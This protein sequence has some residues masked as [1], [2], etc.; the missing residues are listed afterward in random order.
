MTV[1]LRTLRIVSDFSAA[2]Y[3]A[4][5]NEKVAA[6]RAGVA[7]SKAV[8]AA[9]DEQKIKVSSAVPLIEKLSRTYVDGYGTAAK[10][11][12]EVLK[13]ARS[14]DT[15]ASSVEHLELV[16]TGLQ[17]KFGLVADATELT[18]RGY[19]EL[20]AAIENVN[21]RLNQ[22]GGAEQ[23][24]ALASRVEQLRQ[25]FDPTYVAAQRLSSELS[26]L[27]E[28]ER[29]G[30]QITGGYERALE[31]IIVKHDATA[32]AAKR[33]R[34]EYTRLAQEGREA[35]AADRAQAGFN[36]F[37]GI[38]R[39]P[40]SR[41]SDSAAFF[42]E[43]LARQEELARLRAQQEGAGFAADLNQRFAFNGYGTSAQ[44]SA[45]VFAAE[46]ARQD[47]L[48]RLREQQR[49]AAFSSD[50]NDRL[51]VN[52]FGT[53]ARASASA[54]EE[55]ARAAEY[56]ER[57]A[58]SLRAQIDPLGAAQNRLNAELAEYEELARRSAISAEELTQGQAVARQR[59]DATQEN[60]NR[61]PTLGQRVG[62]LQPHQV[63]NLLYQGYDVAQSLALGMPAIQVFL[64]QG[65]QIAQIFQ[66]G[67]GATKALV[68][69]LTPLNIAL[70]GV[71]AAVL[72]GA[73]AWNDY[74]VSTKAVETA[75]AG[76]GRTMAG[77]AA[78]MEA[79]A[80]AGAEAAN[81]SVSAARSLEAQFL[82]T[83]KIGYE[84][85]EQ[86]IGVSKDFAA[87]LGIDSAAAGTKLSEMFA[88][89]AQ[90]AE[91]LYRQY[92]LISPATAEYV[93]RLVAQ[94]RAAEAQSVLL[95]ALPI[96]LAD[97]TEA[98]TAFGRAWEGVATAA[99]NSWDYIGKAIDRATTGPSLE[100]R[101]NDAA[102]RFERFSS[103][104]TP[105]LGF[106]GARR[107]RAEEARVELEDL[108]EQ[109]RRQQQLQA[110][111]DAER[112]QE[113]LIARGRD[114]ALGSGATS[115]VRQQRQLAD[116]IT[117]LQRSLS[118]D[119]LSPDARNDM[120][121]ALE[122]KT[123]VLD[124]LINRQQR[125]AELDRLDIQI[126]Q[127][128]NPLLRADLE[129]RRTRLQMADQEVESSRIAV[130]ADRAR[131]RV[132]EETIAVAA[133]QAR[134]LQ[135]EIEVRT[136]LDNLVAAGTLTRADANR[137][138]QEEATLRPLVAAAAAAEG[139]EQERLLQVVEQLRGAYAGLAEEQKRAAAI[140]YLTSIN[141]R[142]EQLRL[143]QSLIGANQNVRGRAT[144][145]LE[146]EQRIRRMGLDT[147]S[148]MADRIREETD[149]LARQ[150][151][152][153]N[154]QA[155]AWKEVQSS[156]ES[157][158]DSAVERLSEGDWKGA[159]QDVTKE[160]QSSLLK[161][162]VTNPLKNMA[163]GTNYGT[164]EDVGGL[165]GIMSRL[166]GGANGDPAALAAGALSS[167]VG[168]MT[169]TAGTVLVNGGVASS[170]PSLVP[171]NDNLP[172][173]PVGAV[174]RAALGPP[175]TGAALGFIGNYKSGVDPR[176]TDILDTA[177]QQ[178]PGYKVDAMSGFRAGDPRFHGK[179]LATDVQLTEL[180]T[181]RKLGNYQDAASFGAY[182]RFAQ[183][184]RQ[185]QM[186]KYPELA[187]EF[188]W[189]GYFSGGPGKKN[190]VDTMHFDLGG[191]RVGMGGGSWQGGLNSAQRALWPEAQS[192]GMESAA[193]AIGKV[194]T[195]SNTAANG[196]GTFG[197][198]LGQFSQQ[199]MN[200]ASGAN[201][202]AGGGGFLGMFGKLV[203]GISPTSSLWA[204]NTTM[205]SFL[206][207][208]FANGGISDRPAIFGEGPL[209]EAAVPLPD[210]RRIPVMLNFGAQS[211]TRRSGNR[212]VNVYNAPPG[213]GAEV[214]EDEDEYGNEK[215]NVTLSKA[216]SSEANRR[217]S[218]L[219]KTLKTMN[220]RSPRIRR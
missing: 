144:A 27:A 24:T 201:G 186:Q 131:N 81:I 162:T 197:S 127:E 195:A 63:N 93:Q 160:F 97:A 181:G 121:S 87:T 26:E 154:R 7:S 136:R 13:L 78:E 2:Q 139:Q 109:Y 123:R 177:A 6:D 107:R 142:V 219:N 102:G 185:V 187:D 33:Q 140:E 96:R 137:L 12:T 99:S 167:T 80:Q 207:N 51:G 66:V 91:Q 206:M 84:N 120:N 106:G 37:L 147:T 184:A 118:V 205:G 124:S 166:L 42:S 9:V 22:T 34:E 35:A 50:L 215:V 138:L 193:E 194:A 65:P 39:T 208:G 214:S 40:G 163:L 182:E 30:V 149:A 210:G 178:F 72:I 114:V 143:E 19:T 174:S 130:E 31:S 69:A 179:G 180:L 156:T 5:M 148:D 173:V 113:S 115:D 145:A 103:Q 176:L 213:Y 38:D 60:L 48:N 161:L 104:T 150:T 155:D 191:Q 58:T 68:A 110:A 126:A 89:P 159:L 192:K 64:Q 74:L 67:S 61:N 14:Q 49:G 59:F 202:P 16:Y 46:F 90:A 101:M 8:G 211:Q 25:T 199:L 44:Q 23:A 133:G 18:R 73:K 200:A 75:A 32:A 196:L 88:N 36:S 170:L 216:V 190:A 86:L 220:A 98:T 105:Q 28:A 172:G 135:K 56:L 62:R 83:G 57:R 183:T 47:E 217:G 189:G 175:G 17:K 100:D 4:G 76:L 212:Q 21:A 165:K 52:G 171:G 79:A 168:A 70:G 203:G 141:D 43:Q 85:F 41:A 54:F 3:V 77:S 128:R 218:P 111:R 209:P 125:L 108:N 164:I 132:V 92:G 112:R 158:L 204:P 53:S 94:N 151:I 55:A 146:A 11:N 153:V 29:L 15:H 122:A 134:D 117:A 71:A 129:A 1:E 20:A 152:E 45:S 157:A 188:R 95:N 169:V 119:N 82:R 116:D 198:G 10:F